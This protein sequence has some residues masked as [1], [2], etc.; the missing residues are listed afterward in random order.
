MPEAC[1]AREKKH[2]AMQCDTLGEK[3]WKKSAFHSSAT[4]PLSQLG[5]G[6]TWDEGVCFSVWEVLTQEQPTPCSPA[7]PGARES[8]LSPKMPDA[9]SGGRK[10]EET[11]L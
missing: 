2:T 10:Y 5:G 7:G 9:L 1:A 11:Q 4:T 8:S 6:G 3:Q